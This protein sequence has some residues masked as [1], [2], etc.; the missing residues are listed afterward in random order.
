MTRQ[1]RRIASTLAL[2]AILTIPL[3]VTGA[4]AGAQTA[5]TA[6]GTPPAGYN[7]IESNQ[8]FITGT[9]EPDFICAGDANN[10]IRAR[11]KDDIIHAGGGNDVIWGGFGNDTIWAGDGDDLIRAGGG[12]DVVS[13]GN[14]ND[15]AFGGDGMDVLRGE[16]GDDNLT[17]GDGHDTLDGGDGVDTLVGNIGIDEILGGN[18]NDTAQG[19]LGPDTILGGGGDDVLSGGDHDDII[20]GGNGNDRLL[21]GNGQD[22][23]TGGNG[24]DALIGG[25]NPDVLR[26]SAGDD[27][28]D[29]GN[30]L[31]L[32]IGGTGNDECKNAD[33][34]G[35]VCEI[36][37]GIDQFA[38][39]A[40][41]WL[42]VPSADSPG[43]LIAGTNWTP[44][45]PIDVAIL[46]S[47]GVEVTP[48]QVV[49]S[50]AS[51]DWDLVV[52]TA[53]LA[54]AT[55]Q[56]G[57]SAAG[58]V[59]TLT[60]ALDE[61]VWD[62]ATQDLVLTGE[63]GETVEAHISFPSDILVFVE[64][65]TFDQN[66]IAESNFSEVANIEEFE[67]RRSDSDGDVEIHANIS[68]PPTPVVEAPVVA[69][70]VLDAPA[71]Q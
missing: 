20:G 31:N 52:P 11:G 10:I 70:P 5:S 37:D 48:E 13:A 38:P 19:G 27:I 59:K 8:R 49:V 1:R 22:T 29:G 2:T 67:V 63:A 57:D 46:N 35:T 60:P 55:I 4:P 36:L 58:R 64:Q 39:P 47:A 43:S 61:F 54:D 3:A 14:G 42:L 44:N 17:G 33:D 71:A 26:G 7:V 56:A 65:M 28:L 25:G 51:G 41:V 50:N 68:R 9:P 21:G 18:G 30:G 12:R 69:T 53:I 32:A 62:Q 40:R 23:L 66:G 15:D 45:S 16:A 24:N 34:P 6:C